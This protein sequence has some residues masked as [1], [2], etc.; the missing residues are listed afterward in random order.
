MIPPGLVYDPVMKRVLILATFLLPAAAFAAGPQH[1]PGS[2]ASSTRPDV[3]QQ[4]AEA[5]ADCCHCE[6]QCAEPATRQLPPDLS[7]MLEEHFLSV[8]AEPVR[9]PS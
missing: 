3:A 1:S 5:D 9:S 6:E 2:A 4:C 8:Q 7:D